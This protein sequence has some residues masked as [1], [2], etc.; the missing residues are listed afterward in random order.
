MYEENPNWGSF[1]DIGRT[2]LE[3]GWSPSEYV[4]TVFSAMAANG[5]LVLPSNVAAKSSAAYFEKRKK[6]AE[7][8]PE[9]LWNASERTVTELVVDGATEKQALMNPMLSMP[10]WFRVFYPE[11]LDS[12]IVATYGDAAKSEL[13]SELESFIAT[14]NRP[15]LDTFLG[16]WQAKRPQDTPT[17]RNPC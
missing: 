9:E 7:L 8:P 2:C 13:T 3:R 11:E 5:G 4:E 14:K 17:P 6:A 15:A 10:A 16:L 1:V 12:D